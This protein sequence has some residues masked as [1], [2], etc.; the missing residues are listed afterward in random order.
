MDALEAILGRRTWPPAKLGE[1]G[2]DASQLE[3]L[4]AAAAAAPD[5]GL[6]RPFRVV[7]VRG[8]G[9][10]RLGEL[11]AE[12][13]RTERPEAPESEVVKQRAAP[14]RAPLLLLVVLRRRPDHPRI[15]EIEQIAAAAAATQNMLLAARALG[16]EG[17][18]ATGFP[19]A[20]RRVAAGLG[21]APDERLIGILYI[22]TPRAPHAGPPR[23]EPWEVGSEWP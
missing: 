5:H 20:S 2:P 17:K 21:L 18:W 16:F 3:L 8:E 9:R 10:V 23:P 11:F 12:A 4:L 1:P 19:A 15:P 14:L 13:V 22:G 7:V 6:L